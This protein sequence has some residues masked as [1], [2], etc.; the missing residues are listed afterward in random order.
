[1]HALLLT[2]VLQLAPAPHPVPEGQ[3][4]AEM[5]ERLD[6]QAFGPGVVESIE[7]MLKRSARRRSESTGI[8]RT[9]NG[10]A[11]AWVIP[12][13]SAAVHAHSGT[14]YI[15]NRWGDR[16]MGIGFGASVDLDGAWIAGQA[17]PGAWAP[18]VRVIGYRAGREVG[19]TPWFEDVGESPAWF[20]MDLAGVD[21]I[22]VLAKHAL[23]GAG[24]YALDD[25]SFTRRSQAGASEGVVLDFED[26]PWRTVLTGGD[27]GGLTWEAG[28]GDF[29]PPIRV[30]PAPQTAP[31]PPTPAL[32]TL[33][34]SVQ[35]GGGATAPSLKQDFPGVRMFEAGTSVIPPDS[36]GAA[37]LDHFVSIVNTKLTVFDKITGARLVDLP[38]ADFWSADSLG[39]PRV[40]FDPH[41]QRFFA[42]ASSGPSTGR[43]YIA[44]SLT[45]DP[46]GLWY[47]NFI[48]AAQGSDANRWPDYPTLGVD[49]LGFYSAALM[50]GSG[51]TMTIWA[52]DKAPL[53]ATPPVL[54]TVTAWRDRPFHGAIQPC[55]TYGNP[56]GEYL[57]SRRPDG[58]AMR[59]RRIDGPLD[60]PTLVGVGPIT[61]PSNQRPN[62]AP[63]LGSVTDIST[64]DTRPMNAVYRDGSIWTAH[65]VRA[66]GRA[67]C[68]WYEL[69]PVALSAAQIG[70]VS[71][72]VWHYYYPSI[73]VNALGDVV[74]G[75][76]GSHADVFVA[77]FFTGRR[78]FDPA[79]QMAPPVLLRQ[80]VSSYEFLDG[81]GTNRW[82]DYSMTSVDPTDDES[83][84]TIQEHARPGNKWGTWIGLVQFDPCPDLVTN[85]CVTTPTS[86]TAGAVMGSSGSTSLGAGDFT[87]E[88]TQLP[89]QKPGLF[90]YGASSIQTPFGDGFRCVGAGGIGTF[91]LYPI[92]HSDPTGS[93]ARPIDFP[94]SPT[95]AGTGQITGGSTWH[96]QLWFRDP[97]GPGGTGF[98][99]TDSLTVTFCP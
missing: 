1:M 21:R 13:Q 31:S 27:H 19:R 66:S 60:A 3:P 97:T 24:W 78:P 8:A 96:F 98:N 55:V 26:L 71:D 40:V 54:S 89:G 42:L 74:M 6:A 22:E 28:T 84:W 18:A 67:A 34:G 64:G 70:T 11:G 48:E 94:A 82:G 37:G 87:L 5:G 32:E 61:V 88:A 92:A 73:T 46:T 25:L 45:S 39:D 29:T 36:C 50:V 33:P 90:Y 72:P 14:R 69:D 12:Q 95:G 35:V 30:I 91:R 59:I 17:S 41:S 56:P 38:L 23:Q 86:S 79:G 43:L 65:A 63:A 16:R 53:L 80:G 47:K 81:N 9:R 7:Q 85:T 77:C 44:I 57:V 76:S 52:I 10:A 51:C 68:R 20:A 75:F 99:L 58:L 15:T 83:F 49:A 2:T 93:I 4:V 62:G